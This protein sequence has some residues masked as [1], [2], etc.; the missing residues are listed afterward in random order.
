MDKSSKLKK[1]VNASMTAFIA[2]YGQPEAGVEIRRI[3]DR[4]QSIFQLVVI[5]WQGVERI[6][7]VLF[8]LEIKENKVWV[9]EDNTEIGIATFLLNNGLTKQDI[10]LGFYSAPYRVHTEFAVA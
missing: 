10:V 4:T 9:Q 2:E 1:A 7:H 5:G 6:Y 8:H 3:V